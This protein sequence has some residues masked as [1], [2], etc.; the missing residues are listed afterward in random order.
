M[1]QRRP[2]LGESATDVANLLDTHP[3]PSTGFCNEVRLFLELAIP[4]TLLNLG[5]C[6]SPLLTASYVGLKFGKVYLSAFTLANLTGNLCTF[7]LMSGVFSAADT[8]SPQAFGKG[9]FRELG[10]LAIRGVVASVVLLLPINVFLVLYLDSVLVA[11]GQ[12]PVAAFHAAQWYRIFVWALPFFVVY[13]AAW[14]F[15][16]AQHVMRPLIYVSV[17]CCI[18]ILPIA[19]EVCTE[20][21]GFL[22]SAVAYVIFQ[23]FQPAL[24]LFYLSWVEPH[25]PGSWSGLASWKEALRWKP[26]MDYLHLGAGGILAQSECIYSEALGLIIGK[27]GVLQLSVHTIPNQVIMAVCMAPFAFGIALAIRMGVTLTQSVTRAKQIVVWTTVGSAILF[28]CVTIAMYVYSDAIFSIFTTDE[29]VKELAHKVWWKVCLFNFNVVI[30]A[31]FT[32]VATGLGMQWVLG[33]VNFFFLFFFGIPVTYHFAVVRGGGLDAAWTWINAPYTC[34]NATLL[35]IFVTKDWYLVQAKI[36]SGE[37]VEPA[38][39]DPPES[40]ESTGLLGNG[41]P[42]SGYGDANSA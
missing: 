33:A 15:L 5:F 21:M 14:K 35:T 41:A 16:S 9:D 36:R 42:V 29:E 37:I 32:G 13:N 10:L 24:L 26:M 11:M 28:G 3:Q 34:M 17:F 18:A 31:I 8:L 39:T 20:R 4:T 22:G 6:L 19:L 25:V 12:D 27:L 7:S 1:P 30:F 40:S 23:A 2:S 38:S